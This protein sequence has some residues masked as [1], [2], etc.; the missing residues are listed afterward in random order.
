[1]PCFCQPRISRL[2]LIFLYDG[3]FCKAKGGIDVIAKLF[4]CISIGNF[5]IPSISF[6]NT[7]VYRWQR[8]PKNTGYARPVG[9]DVVTFAIK[10]VD[11]KAQ[12]I[13]KHVYIQTYICLQVTLPGYPKVS[14]PA[15]SNAV[16]CSSRSLSKHRPRSCSIGLLVHISEIA[17]NTI[18]SGQSM[19]SP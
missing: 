12:F 6:Y 16:C 7:Q 1:M 4:D 15:F 18:I 14:Q 13:F 8:Y 17:R 9:Q 11:H 3:I 10:P 5:P 2:C 19:R